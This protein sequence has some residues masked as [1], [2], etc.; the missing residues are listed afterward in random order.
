[1]TMK[2]R[3]A[4]VALCVLGASAYAQQTYPV[5]ATPAPAMAPT[6]AADVSKTQRTGASKA[7]KSA[8]QKVAHKKTAQ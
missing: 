7:K 5:S 1:M 8:H 3:L 2:S 4:A 6:Q